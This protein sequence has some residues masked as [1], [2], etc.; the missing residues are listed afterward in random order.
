MKSLLT[1]T[2]W[3]GVG[4]IIIGLLSYAIQ[5]T[6]II[7][8]FDSPWPRLAHSLWLV[9]AGLVLTAVAVWSRAT[10]GRIVILLLSL[11]L[12]SWLVATTIL[13]YSEETIRFANGEEQLS[14]TLL[15]P[16]DAGLHPAMI[17]IHG[18]APNTRAPYRAVAEQFVRQGVATL[19]Y[20]KHGFGASTGVLPY[21]YK[22]LALDAQAGFNT[23]QQHPQIDPARIGFIGY[24]EGGFV[25]PLAAA[26]LGNAATLILISGGGVSPART[27][28][29]EMENRLQQ[30]DYSTAEITQAISLM[31]GVDNYYRT[32]TGEA[33]VMAA[34]EQ[35]RQAPW[36][37][38]AFELD[39]ATFPDS[40]GAIPFTDNY[41][42]NL[43]FDPLPLLA[44]LDMPM[45]FVFGEADTQVPVTESASAIRT[46]LMQTGRQNFQ[47]EIFPGADH[48][49]FIDYQPAPGYAELL[50]AWLQNTLGKR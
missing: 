34:I 14:G 8:F 42:A 15:L 41:P 40:L 4:L 21:T 6:P 49:I 26:R 47:I 11:L 37:Q 23:L 18:K 36:F 1:K 39:P 30:A 9:L 16:R 22:Q 2:F 17:V 32:G 48:L 24:S 29:Y 27:V 7:F 33:D 50:S 10:K 35:A 13:V 28:H 12:V 43:D 44:A 45:L 20:D 38:T 19:I 5:L 3:L 31:H 25:A 46:T